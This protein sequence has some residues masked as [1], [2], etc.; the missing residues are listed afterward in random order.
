[1]SG[2][3]PKTGTGN[4]FVRPGILASITGNLGKRLLKARL[5]QVCKSDIF[6]SANFGVMCHRFRQLGG[7]HHAYVHA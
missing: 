5:A 2:I 1:M 6:S 4:Y 7:L 3:F